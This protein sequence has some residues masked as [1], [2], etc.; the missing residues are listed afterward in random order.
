M[1]ICKVLSHDIVFEVLNKTTKILSNARKN[2][3][4]ILAGVMFSSAH[5]PASF[6]LSHRYST[7]RYVRI[8]VCLILS[9][10]KGRVSHRT[11]QINS[12]YIVSILI[13]TYG[14]TKLHVYR[15]HMRD[16]NFSQPCYRCC[17]SPNRVNITRFRSPSVR[18]TCLLNSL[19]V[20]MNTAHSRT[21]PEATYGNKPSLNI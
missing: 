6:K 14:Q 20:H 18:I 15:G 11:V 5:Y 16:R 19:H 7:P 9:C 21:V 8:H 13:F 4:T 10:A 12:L 2:T 17:C 3:N 1:Q